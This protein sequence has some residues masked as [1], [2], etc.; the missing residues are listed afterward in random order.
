[1]GRNNSKR[2]KMR[3]QRGLES[4]QRTILHYVRQKITLR[5]ATNKTMSSKSSVLRYAK[6]LRQLLSVGKDEKSLVL[7]ATGRPAI[8]K[9]PALKTKVLE[10]V[11]KYEHGGTPIYKKDMGA[12]MCTVVLSEHLKGSTIP[13]NVTIQ[14]LKQGRFSR[15]LVRNFIDDNKEDLSERIT[16][17]FVHHRHIMHEQCM[18][19]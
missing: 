11:L 6:D 9:N 1:M 2:D 17:P 16:K 3:Q 12:L 13:K 10:Q 5:Q 14:A 4:F 7:R 19:Q 15:H 8:F 18:P